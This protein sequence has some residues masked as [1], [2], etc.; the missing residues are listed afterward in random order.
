ML[1][2]KSRFCCIRVYDGSCVATNLDLFLQAPI[3]PSFFNKVEI[4]PMIKNVL[5]ASGGGKAQLSTPI[6]HVLSDAKLRRSLNTA[7]D[8]C[9]HISTPTSGLGWETWSDPLLFEL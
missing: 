7:Q 9:Q 6:P 2:T 1:N 8:L 4:A 5:T 3:R